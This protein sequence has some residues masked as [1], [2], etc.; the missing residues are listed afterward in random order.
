MF[1]RILFQIGACLFLS[2]SCSDVTRTIQPAHPGLGVTQSK[3]AFN[4]SSGN[5]ICTMLTEWPTATIYVG[6]TLVI[7][8]NENLCDSSTHVYIG[9]GTAS[10]YTNDPSVASLSTVLGY[11]TTVTGVADG[12]AYVSIDACC[13]QSGNPIHNETDVTVQHEPLAVSVSGPTSVNTG[14]SCQFD[15]NP[16]GG[17]SGYSYQWTADGTIV[18]SSTSSQ[19]TVQFTADGT[20]S[21]SVLVTDSHSQQHGGGTSVTSSTASPPAITCS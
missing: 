13:D 17:Y 18:G 10:F 16:S 4:S 3:P 20:H 21:V 1:R 5:Y 6:H 14:P 2:V 12:T 7:H 9:D 19:V 8:A 11:T 15:A